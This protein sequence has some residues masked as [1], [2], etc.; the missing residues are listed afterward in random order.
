[1]PIYLIHVSVGRQLKL[2]S[3]EKFFLVVTGLN[4]A[5]AGSCWYVALFTSLEVGRLLAL[6]RE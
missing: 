6:E 1:M 4:H 5:S 2:G 3:P